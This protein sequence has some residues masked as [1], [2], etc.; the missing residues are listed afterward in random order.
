VSASGVGVTFFGREDGGR[1][2]PVVMELV[3]WAFYGADGGGDISATGS[4]AS[5][6]S[7]FGGSSA[8]DTEDDDD[9]DD[10]ADDYG[11]TGPQ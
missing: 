6:S 9:S 5:Y 4:A 3:G 7:G 8:F 10:D 2:P 1:F 11:M